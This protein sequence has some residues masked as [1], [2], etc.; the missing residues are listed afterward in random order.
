MITVKAPEQYWNQTGILSESGKKIASYGQHTLIIGGRTALEAAGKDI[1]NSLNDANV[2]CHV[3]PFE[4]YCT[5]E[6]IRSFSERAQKRKADLVLGIGGGKVLDLAK[7]AGDSLDIPV[8][9]VPTIPA[10]CAAW[11][12]LSIVYDSHG[13]YTG[14]IK[15]KKSPV[16][17]L[18]DPHI[19]AAAPKRYLA[20]GIGDTIVKWYEVAP[21]TGTAPEDIFERVNLQTAKLVLDILEE[22][23]EEA[24]RS[25]G[26]GEVTPSFM[27][28]ADSIILLA[29]MVGT[30][31]SGGA[32][33]AVPHSIH[34]SLTWLPETRGTLHG[35][36][37][38]FGLLVQSVLAGYDHN[39]VLSL[40]EFLKKLDLPVTLK[41][42]GI[43]GNLREKAEQIARGVSISENA[44]GRLPFKVD[45][46]SLAKAIL[47]TDAIG[48]N[49]LTALG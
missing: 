11:S 1:V 15:L 49:I 9:T 31:Q 4:G 18:S 35:E 17:V 39:E 25:A 28:T 20:A 36:K 10:T 24:Y 40:F 37:V 27:Q 2:S 33:A 19:L 26:S 43:Q 42:L 13:R 12:A 38:A 22:H 6:S 21:N 44:A 7:A 8:I 34:H 46:E 45:A 48:Q 3:E 41:Q 5:E 47:E 32:R 14:K 29:G 16:L 30:I 23:A